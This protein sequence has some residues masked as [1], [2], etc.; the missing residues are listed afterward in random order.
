MFPAEARLYP[1]ESKRKAATD[2][3]EICTDHLSFSTIHGGNSRSQTYALEQG[4]SQNLS[5]RCQYCWLFLNMTRMDQMT[6][7]YQTA[8]NL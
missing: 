2:P 6:L 7:K 4:T 5:Q 8:P 3:P 1:T